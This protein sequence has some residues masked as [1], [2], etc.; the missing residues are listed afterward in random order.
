MRN[1][2][3]LKSLEPSGPVAARGARSAGGGTSG[4]DRRSNAGGL[5]LEI[6][7]LAN[8]GVAPAYLIAAAR[9]AHKEGVSP[10]RALLASGAIEETFFY[11]CLARHLGVSFIDE[12][13]RL[14]DVAVKT[15]PQPHHAGLVAYTGPEGPAWLAAPR[16][17]GLTTLLGNMKRGGQKTRLAI[18]TPSHLSRSLREAARRKIAAEA[19]FSL[20]SADADLSA[21]SGLNL[22]QQFFIGAGSFGA[23]LSVLIPAFSAGY[24]W[25]VFIG[26]MFL[27]A[28]IFRLFVSAAAIGAPRPRREPLEDHQLPVYTVLV[29]LYKEARI[30]RRLVAMLDQIDY[31]RA[32]LDIKLILEEDDRETRYALESLPLSPIY[33]IIVAPSGEPRTKPRAL[34]VALP[35]ARGELIAV[36]DAEDA[37]DALQ[38]RLAAEGF[39]RAPSQLACLQAKLVIENVQDRWLTQLFAIEYAALFELQNVGL[40]DL[41]LPFP[42]SG[43]SNHFRTSVLREIHGWDAWNV[44]E[45][46][47]VGL[48]LARFGYSID[49]LDSITHEEA[50]V[51]IDAWLKQ[52]QRWFKGWWQTL[53]TISRSPLTLI[54]EIGLVRAG[55]IALL[56]VS[57]LFGPLF[58]IPSSLL[59][60]SN[61][62]LNGVWM[63]E[64][65]AGVC[66]AT[67]WTSVSLLGLGSLFW[68]ALFG[69]KQQ[70]LL[71]LWPVLPL[72]LPYY[73]LH[74]VAAWMAIYELFR[75]P[76]HWHKTEHGL[77]STSQR[78]VTKPARE[79]SL[80]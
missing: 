62:L 56:F 67:L 69:M 63:P 29:A 20:L 59:L 18:T 7:F 9:L 15:Y 58:W 38:L 36:F 30:A 32:K 6:A 80:A 57:L 33:E 75:R 37:P 66:L 26:L 71:H 24:F 3:A 60:L 13:L 73:C 39:A 64:D 52:R 68:H 25:A 40:A 78:V 54:R 19:S 49:M 51:S 31:P 4:F 16:D 1:G 79:Q 2:Q 43:S 10:D 34:N 72:L 77:A 55:A 65:F 5:P 12:P 44:T 74:A 70:R 76:F 23:A 47:D 42:V 48:R 11:R 14:L 61:I 46:A 27:A 45:D 50:P 53:I 17:K 22:K 41:G 35:L 8:Y 28:I 21:Q